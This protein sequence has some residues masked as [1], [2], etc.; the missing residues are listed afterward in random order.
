LKRHW[1]HTLQ[2]LA[3]E[4]LDGYASVQPKTAQSCNNCH[5]YPFCRIA[6]TG[7]AA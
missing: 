5:V 6:E 7:S 4:Y 1:Q 3:Q 2:L